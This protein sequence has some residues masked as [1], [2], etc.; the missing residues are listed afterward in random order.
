LEH[1][2]QLFF[3]D[4]S[5]KLDIG[6]AGATL[7]HRCRVTRGLR[8]VPPRNDK[9]CIWKLFEKEIE[10]FDHEFKALVGSPFSERENSMR[11]SPPREIR[12]FRSTRQNT[13]RAQ[14]NVISPI[15]VIQNLS[16]SRHEHGH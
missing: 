12:Q 2:P 16:V 13:V 6:I 5:A 15:L 3:R 8:V 11:R 7:L 10:G 9:L 14:M 4:V 1:I